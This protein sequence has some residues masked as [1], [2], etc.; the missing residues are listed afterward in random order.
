MKKY[1]ARIDKLIIQIDNIQ[2]D[3]IDKRPLNDKLNHEE[4]LDELTRAATCL[5]D[6]TNIF[7]REDAYEEAKKQMS[8]NL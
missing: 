5:E 2:R 7:D 1:S 4:A 3:I 6:V 8:F